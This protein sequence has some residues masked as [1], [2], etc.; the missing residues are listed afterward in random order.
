MARA[1][2]QSLSATLAAA[3]QVATA[4]TLQS[5]QSL[6]W[7]SVRLGSNTLLVLVEATTP[8]RP[9]NRCAP[10]CVQQ[11]GVGRGEVGA[12]NRLLPRFAPDAGREHVT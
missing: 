10:G 4:M 11:S 3:M 7:S 9:K 6:N 1:P 12:R 2:S 8:D 5:T